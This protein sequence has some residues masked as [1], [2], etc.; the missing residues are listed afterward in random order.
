MVHEVV[1]LFSVAIMNAY[2]LQRRSPHHNP[3]ATQ[4]AQRMLPFRQ[5][6]IKKLIGGRVY[7][8]KQQNNRS[9][10]DEGRFNFSLGHFLVSMPTRS[11]CKVHMQRVDTQYACSVCYIGMCPAPCFERFHTL[12]NYYY[13]DKDHGDA[14]VVRGTVRTRPRKRAR[15]RL[16]I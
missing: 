2:H 13:D 1:L 8:R 12:E 6:L 16:S 10:P 3:P 9:L 15:G 5:E 14:D 7:R 11:Y 4:K